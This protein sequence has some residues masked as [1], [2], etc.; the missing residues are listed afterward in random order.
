MQYVIPDVPQELKIQTQLEQLAEK[1][2]ALGHTNKPYK[3]FTHENFVEI[4]SNI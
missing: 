4:L 3:C 1:E 2:E